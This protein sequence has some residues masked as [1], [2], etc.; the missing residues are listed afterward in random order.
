M[1]TEFLSDVSLA[2][3]WI[4]EIHSNTPWR[5]K[6]EL[7]RALQFFYFC[8][9]FSCCHA[10][11]SFGECKDVSALINVLFFCPA[12][13]LKK[14]PPPPDVENAELFYEDE[15]FQIGNILL[16]ISNNQQ[17]INSLTLMTEVKN[18][19]INERANWWGH[20]HCF[21]MF[22]VVLLFF[23]GNF[24]FVSFLFFLRISRKPIKYVHK[25]KHRF[26]TAK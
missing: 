19:E 21:S 13:R 3:H 8:F 15:D 16:S 14:C 6:K 17:A 25:E 9:Y 7:L 4:T 23:C 18:I 22:L 11:P 5:G 10:H 20:S 1:C 26:W 24:D 2:P 12:Y